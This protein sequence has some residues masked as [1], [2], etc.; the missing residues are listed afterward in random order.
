M[1]LTG[2]ARDQVDEGNRH[3][4]DTTWLRLIGPVSSPWSESRL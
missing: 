2:Q 3:V 1:T 4:D